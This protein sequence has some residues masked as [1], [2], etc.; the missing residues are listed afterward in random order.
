[1]SDRIGTA[2]VDLGE[3]HIKQIDCQLNGLWVSQ[4]VGPLIRHSVS[5]VGL[6]YWSLMFVLS[7]HSVGQ[8]C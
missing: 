8:F 1:M 3:V 5:F 4:S 6:F 7:F 2:R